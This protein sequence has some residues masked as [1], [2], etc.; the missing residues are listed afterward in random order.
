M[1]TEIHHDIQIYVLCIDT[2]YKTVLFLPYVLSI[3]FD[4]CYLVECA[5][6]NLLSKLYGE[7]HMCIGWIPTVK[8]VNQCQQKNH[9]HNTNAELALPNPQRKDTESNLQ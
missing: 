5:Y 9:Y 6:F 1:R 4:V 7:S 2:C 8:N 3:E